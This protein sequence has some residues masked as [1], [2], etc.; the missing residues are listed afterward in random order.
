M[1]DIKDIINETKHNYKE[2]QYVIIHSIA[3]EKSSDTWVKLSQINDE[4]F[5]CKTL[6]NTSWE[7]RDEW[8]EE[9]TKDIIKSV[10]ERGD[11][12]PLVYQGDAGFIV[13][14]KANLSKYL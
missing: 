6:F 8:M 1:K 7:D 9:D 3:G 10:K 4:K 12:E 14:F 2:D 5:L 11:K 13:I